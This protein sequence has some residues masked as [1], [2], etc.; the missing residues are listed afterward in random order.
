MATVYGF[1]RFVGLDADDAPDL[2]ARMSKRELGVDGE[3]YG[4]NSRLLAR[5]HV[6][7][8]D[9]ATS[10]MEKLFRVDTNTPYRD[11]IAA[12][13]L[14]SRIVDVQQAAS[15]VVDRLGIGCPAYGVERACSGFPAATQLGWQLSR[16]TERPVAVIAAEVISG[17]INW[18]TP[19]DTAADHQ[20][21]RGQAS[22]LF[23][24][25]AAAVLIRPDR[26]GRVHQ[27]LDAWVDEV[28]DDKEL[29]QKAEIEDSRDPWGNCRPG[30]TGCISMPGRRGFYLVKRA[31]EIMADSVGRSLQQAGQAVLCGQRIQ[32]VVAH[33]ANGLIINRLQAKL[34]DGDHAPHVWDCIGDSGN[35]VSASIPLAMAQVQDQLPPGVLVAMPSVGA[36]GPGYRPQ[37]LSTGCVLVRTGKVDDAC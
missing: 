36:G 34:T 23:G 4:I 1:D 27:I 2:L 12:V 7:V 10:V 24:D 5:P 13:V 31:P 37:V 11:R 20:R 9:L 35:T 3:R 15:Q 14:S 16:Q 29:I 26:D 22:K 17:N 30:N 21:A 33:Q 32:H 19:D 18:E 28:P 6:K 25:G 8:V